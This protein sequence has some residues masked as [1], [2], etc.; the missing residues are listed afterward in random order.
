MSK[1]ISFYTGLSFGIQFL[2]C[3]LLGCA[4][5]AVTYV[6][7]TMIGKHSMKKRK[8]LEMIKKNVRK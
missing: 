8:Q 4:I 1:V 5:I 2:L 6:V 3:I 7:V